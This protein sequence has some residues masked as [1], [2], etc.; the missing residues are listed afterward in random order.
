MS[1]CIADLHRGR[2]CTPIMSLSSTAPRVKEPQL[3]S[4]YFL[5][6]Y[7]R[8]SH[9]FPWVYSVQCHKV[10]QVALFLVY[11]SL[12]HGSRYQGTP[13]LIVWSVICQLTSFHLLLYVFISI[14]ATARII[15]TYFEQSVFFYNTFSACHQRAICCLYS[16]T[17]IFQIGTDRTCS[18]EKAKDALN[19]VSFL[20]ESQE[21]VENCGHQT[22]NGKLEAATW[23]HRRRR[24][25]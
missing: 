5:S 19:K 17:Q 20:S 24:E 7:L 21:K 13:F 6:L 11:L 1:R 14:S 22:E 25:T 10:G 9:F 2:W 18:P 23:G 3:V 12:H 8:L 4:A 16:M 15:D